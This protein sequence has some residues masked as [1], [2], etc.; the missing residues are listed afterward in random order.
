MII[1]KRLSETLKIIKEKEIKITS[2]L[3]S[4][5]I[6]YLDGTKKKITLLKKILLLQK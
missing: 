3:Y 2:N 1:K 4:L 6:M 5:E